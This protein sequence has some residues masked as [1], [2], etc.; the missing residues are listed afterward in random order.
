MPHPVQPVKCDKLAECM[1]QIKKA[2][3]SLYSTDNNGTIARSN[4]RKAGTS[5]GEYKAYTSGAL[6][7]SNLGNASY[8]NKWYA[9]IDLELINNFKD[10]MYSGINTKDGTHTFRLNIDRALPAYTF[11]ISYYSHFDVVLEFDYINRVVNVIS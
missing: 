1:Y 6:T 2:W 11:A 10:A 3:G 7:D 4:F 8:S 9:C 5:S